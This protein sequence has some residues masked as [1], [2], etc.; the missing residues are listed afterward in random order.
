MG[1]TNNT[2]MPLAITTGCSTP[3]S[4]ENTQATIAYHISKQ[5][6]GKWCML[7]IH[8]RFPQITLYTYMV[9]E[10]LIIFST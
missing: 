2:L 5:I 1:N 4:V 9:D 8:L 10:M 6:L 3:L 7:H